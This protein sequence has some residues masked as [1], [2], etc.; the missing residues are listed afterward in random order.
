MEFQ[1]AA[2][3]NVT[4]REDGERV[5]T[6]RRTAKGTQNLVLPFGSFI[7]QEKKKKYSD[8][9]QAQLAQRV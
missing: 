7:P 9:A 2:T 4:S 1:P 3:C 6:Q 5:W 8:H